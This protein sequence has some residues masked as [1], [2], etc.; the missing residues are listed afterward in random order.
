MSELN[1]KLSIYIHVYY[2]KDVEI[3]NKFMPYQL[4][5]TLLF[6]FNNVDNKLIK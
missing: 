1:I 5:I 6:C 4:L 2:Y 3:F